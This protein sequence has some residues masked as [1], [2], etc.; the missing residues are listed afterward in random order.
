MRHLL[1]TPVA[2][3]LSSAALATRRTLC[4]VRCGSGG[5]GLPPAQRSGPSRDAAP[6]ARCKAQVP[7][8]Q[9]PALGEEL[10]PLA[11]AAAV[12]SR[13]LA[14]KAQ[15]GQPSFGTAPSAP[16]SELAQPRRCRCPLW[17]PEGGLPLDTI[18][19]TT[20]LLPPLQPCQPRLTGFMLRLAVTPLAAAPLRPQHRALA[21]PVSPA[22]RR[23][24]IAG[25]GGHTVA[26]HSASAHGLPA[27][28]AGQHFAQPAAARSPTLIAAAAAARPR[29]CHPCSCCNLAPRSRRCA[30]ACCAHRRRPRQ[31]GR[32]SQRPRAG[33]QAAVGGASGDSVLRCHD[34]CWH[35]AVPLHSLRFHPL[36]GGLCVAHDGCVPAI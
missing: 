12:P 16:P 34:R 2:A 26:A 10:S 25:E 9:L 11:G 19:P 20:L 13:S 33:P 7:A 36:G 28:H 24:L 29:P 17:P 27:M 35:P 31:Q 6:G 5:R 3:I 1:I 32:F 22:V 15:G 18:A 4:T 30:G 23:P 21:P 14:S 8:A